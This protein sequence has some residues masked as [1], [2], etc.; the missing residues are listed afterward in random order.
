MWRC[1]N[2]LWG[3]CSGEPKWGKSAKLIESSATYFGGSCKLNPETCGKYQTLT[4]QLEGKTLPTSHYKVG[5]KRRVIPIKND[6][7]HKDKKR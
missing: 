5:K 7:A 2:N 4:Q 1:V 6:K 3:Y